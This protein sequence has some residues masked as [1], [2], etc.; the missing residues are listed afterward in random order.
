[1]VMNN[2]DNDKKGVVV[3]LDALGTRNHD[4]EQTKKFCYL[5]KK[6]IDD[7]KEIWKL[8]QGQF[9]YDTDLK[10]NLPDPEIATFQDSIV[11]CWSEQE[12][13]SDSLPILLSAGQWLIDAIPLAIGE[14]DLFFRGSISYGKYIFDSSKE[15]VTVIGPAVTD[16]YNCHNI[17]DW[18]GVT[19]TPTCQEEYIS[20]LNSIAAKD[21]QPLTSVIDKYHFLFVPYNVP[22]HEKNDFNTSKLELFSVAWPQISIKI[23]KTKSISQILLLKCLSEHPLYKPK[24]CNSYAFQKWYKESGKYILP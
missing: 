17:A 4:I 3:F 6:F 12:Q 1:M 20:L 19:Q 7:A 23:E 15:N 22:L 2:C 18:I 8:R 11:I 5:K 13:K 16:A 10:L 24:Y 14:Y 21:K 9:F